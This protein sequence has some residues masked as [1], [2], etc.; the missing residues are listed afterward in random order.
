MRI[1]NEWVGPRGLLLLGAT[2]VF[3][4]ALAVHGYGRG[5]V[6]SGAT[7]FASPAKSSK[8]PPS[9]PLKSTITSTSPPS[10]STS[11]VSNPKLG[12]LL[13]STQYA[14]YAYQLYPGQESSQTKL[15]TAGF[16]VRITPS[17]GNIDVSVSAT[18]STQGA[19]SSTYP[20]SD[21]VYFIE[22]SL[23]DDSGNSEYNYGDDGVLV[24]NAD[25]RIVQ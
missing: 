17:A 2:G 23:G 1:S 12:P 16:D 18:G 20:A 4:L 14:S 8:A 5:S 10:S 21:H 22:A 6:V 19:Q 7:A 11:S 13:S 25:G 24:T 3:G 9:R 15:A